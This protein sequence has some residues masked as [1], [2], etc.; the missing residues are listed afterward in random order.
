MNASDFWGV[1]ENAACQTGPETGA[2][3]LI[4][5]FRLLDVDGGGTGF[6]S[7]AAIRRLCSKESSKVPVFTGLRREVIWTDNLAQV[8]RWAADV[9]TLAAR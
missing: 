7:P 2:G 4:S 5:E 1:I 3:G 8:M 9:D 6:M